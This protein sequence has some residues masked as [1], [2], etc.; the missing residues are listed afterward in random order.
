MTF[1][2]LIIEKSNRSQLFYGIVTIVVVHTSDFQGFY[3][4]K[5]RV[6]NVITPPQRM[7]Y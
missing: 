4:Y 3:S 5:E 2:S 7:S 1:S 6:E